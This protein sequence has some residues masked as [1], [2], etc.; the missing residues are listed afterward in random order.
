M[1]KK[2][3]EAAAH[4]ESVDKDLDDEESKEADE[5]IHMEQPSS[6]KKRARED[7][8]EDESKSL[9]N[10]STTNEPNQKVIRN[11]SIFAAPQISTSNLYS[12][13]S[14]HY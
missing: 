8:S 7:I 2:S 6:R 9:S 11:E 3:I 5:T 13:Q 10:K 12:F 14:F 4:L 1:H